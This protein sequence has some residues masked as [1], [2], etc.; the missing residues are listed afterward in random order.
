MSYL[1]FMQEIKRIRIL[2]TYLVLSFLSISSFAQT[3]NTNSGTDFWFGFTLTED[4]DA[5][6]YVVYINT[7]KTTNGT[8]SIPGFAW[9]QSF[10]AIAGNT[11]RIVL[12]PADVVIT[13]FTAPVSQAINVVADSNISVFAAIEY[14]ERSD[15]SCILP[16]S[17]LG[18][19]Y[20][21]IDYGL[22]QS[23]SEFMIV[24]QGCT[25]S[26]EIIPSQNISVGGNHPAGVPYTEVLQPGQVFLVQC[27]SDLTGSMVLSLNHAETGVI[28]AAN[29]NCLYCNAT[30][31][32]FYEELQP[33][34]TWGNSF[35][36]LPTPQ[37]QDQC[38]VLSDQNG[39]VVDFV[40][41][42]GTNSQTINAG[43]YYDTT[44]NY[45][46]PVYINSTN[47]ITVGRFMRTGFCNN[48]YITNPTQ[49]GDPSEVII[50]ANEQMYLDTI[51]FY[52]SRT[53]DIDSTY[54]QVVTRTQDKNSVFLDNVNIG[55]FFNVLIPNPIYSFASLT[56]LPGSHTLTT[57]GQGFIAYTCG[58]GYLDAISCS[59]GVFLKEI[60]ITT[61]TVEP[62]SC[63]ASDGSATAYASGIPPFKYKWS[64]GQTT[65]TATGL[66]AGIYTVTVSDSDC[67]PHQ[68]TA[69]LTI[70]GK[71]GYSASVVDTNPGCKISKG[72]STVFPAGGTSPY[73]YMWSNG[74]T[75]QKDTGLTA[76][77]YSCTITDN[78]GC[79]Y[80]ID[81]RIY[82]YTPLAIG[83]APFND[84]IC[85]DSTT[86]L[87]VYGVN[88]GIYSWSPHTGLSCYQCP[89]PIAS[90]ATTT[91]FTI[92]G[93]DSNGCSAS[94]TVTI[95]I[96]QQ[97]SPVI[98]GKDSICAGYADTLTVT[99]GA[100]YL[101]SN[102]STSSSIVVSPNNTKT[103]SVT[104][105]SYLQCSS[106][107]TSY[108]VYV[109]P[110]PVANIS[111]SSDT[112][113]KGDSIE[114]TGSGGLKYL[115]S[116]NKT[117]PSIWVSPAVTNT[118]TLIAFS[119]TCSGSATAT[120]TV[121]PQFTATLSYIHD[122]VCPHDTSVL[123]INAS[124]GN[125][126][127]K[128]NNG[129]S[130]S[131]IKVTDTANTTYTSIVYGKCDSVVNSITVIVI[132]F[133]KPMITGYNLKCKG[134][135]DTLTVSGGTSY[136]WSNGSTS[137][138][139]FTG[140][141]NADS[142][143]FVKTENIIGCS[144]EDSI[145]IAV[146]KPPVVSTS[147]TKA[148]TGDTIKIT[149]YASGNG[150]F[151]YSWS[152]TADSN[153]TIN[154]I[155][156]SATTYTVNVSNGCTTSATVLAAPE[157]PVLY[158]CCDTVILNGES[159]SLMA[160]GF[161]HYLW[162]PATGLNCDTCSNAIAT[163]S[164]TTTYTIT[165]N[166]STGCIVIKEIT[167]TVEP[168]CSSFIVPDV[169]TPNGDGINDF[170]EIKAENTSQYS[171]IIYDRWGREVFKSS[172]P[173]LYWDGKT[174]N[175]A[176][177]ADGVYYYILT[178]T[179]EGNKDTKKGFVEIIR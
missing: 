33:V 119:G 159:V 111:P 178:T 74:Q 170:F 43:Q 81:T 122:T 54:I 101:W 36:F 14:P 31:N 57:T 3:L 27:D 24:A 155:A 7:L 96:F 100:T 79:I 161:L 134:M 30:A 17:L 168:P 68:D 158:A 114:L 61:A 154:V 83:I 77:S 174:E 21:V 51:V 40:T 172:N 129:A 102:G 105:Y 108:T 139:Y 171:I 69:I 4:L 162:N 151:S 19:Q 89:S 123:I 6:N 110:A 26:V 80:Y 165:A 163:P 118:Y 130:T 58:L 113:C 28:A 106:H 146:K 140:D 176:N 148:C 126:I 34:N 137:S 153:N 8:V 45:A 115:W 91:T 109:V 23:F 143:L 38:R 67:V 132:P 50:D 179:C 37:A 12:P 107:D 18:N 166:D 9:S 99:G 103:V 32:P 117:S 145:T 62:G 29:W 169:F 121:R 88:T 15:N 142:T 82:A 49:K 42:T 131:S 112:I 133:P 141:V 56:I 97:P 70:S 60:N 73:T 59:A 124:G 16:V 149:A 65:Q 10:T 39:T 84:S 94:S 48:Y 152:P 157:N 135:K 150:P 125:V 63:G 2:L 128:W 52:V 25:D 75:N 35:V 20:Y 144:V 76:G 13:S 95:Y 164:V 160:K 138:A 53:P 167:V 90:P 86:Q 92:S 5:A 1:C 66:I 11:T 127:Y 46:S 120:V 156:D 147:F 64:N 98:R 85:S 55:S 22:C 116:N 175:G 44:V 177:A 41:N 71:S 136:L 173:T 87:H 47:P 104:A 72:N 93:V 78:T